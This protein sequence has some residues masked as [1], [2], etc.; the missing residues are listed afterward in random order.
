LEKRGKQ[1][2]PR[3]EGGG[4]EGEGAREKGRDGPNNVY[5]YE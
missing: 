5:T 4:E 2:L 1:V 3:N